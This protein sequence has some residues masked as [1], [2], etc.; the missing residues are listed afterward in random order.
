MKKIITHSNHAR[1]CLFAKAF[2]YACRLALQKKMLLTV[3]LLTNVL[4]ASFAQKA[5]G[6]LSLYDSCHVQ[7]PQ[8]QTAFTLKAVGVG[9]MLRVAYVIPSN[10]TPQPNG[11][12]N[13]QNAIK[14]GQQFFKE[15]MEQNGFGPKTFVFE[16]E[17]DGVTP[18]INVVHVAE[19]DEYLRGD[20]WGR[21]QQAAS[22]AGISL[23][24]PGEV[25]VV[26]PETH[27]MFPD[28]SG[29]G[30]VALGAGFGSGNGGG[31]SMIGSNALPLFNP[32]MI[33]DDTPYDGKVLPELGPYPMKQDICLV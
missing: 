1:K 24:A 19:T 7:P 4:I 9:P 3:I 25:W 30:G 8:Q 2:G 14:L 10:R 22:N 28:G 6:L 15:Q 27:L 32:A 33:T 18:L 16:T 23:W 17:A 11:V 29:A 13:L 26:I 21:A 20:L 31:V 12:A 5:P